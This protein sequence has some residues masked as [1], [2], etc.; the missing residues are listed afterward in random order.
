MNVIPPPP[1]PELAI[2]MS[3]LLLLPALLA[4]AVIDCRRLEINP[5]LVAIATIA[6]AVL[7]APS[8]P[9]VDGL[10]GSAWVLAAALLLRRWRQGALGDGDLYLYAM[11]GFLTGLSGLAAWALLHALAAMIIAMPRARRRRRSVMRTGMPAAV[12][13]CPAALLVMLL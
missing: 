4:V 2:I 9:W 13:A 10:L 1:A 6:G 11:C 8:G 12:T 7:A 5:H 3:W